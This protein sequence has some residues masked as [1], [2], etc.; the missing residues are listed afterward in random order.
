M[1]VEPRLDA[2]RF[3]GLDG[4]IADG[5]AVRATGAGIVLRTTLSSF[6]VEAGYGFLR[7]QGAPGLDGRTHGSFHI[8]VATQSFDLWKRH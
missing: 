2:A 8:A 7:Y 6:F 1:E 3:A 4:Q 5:A